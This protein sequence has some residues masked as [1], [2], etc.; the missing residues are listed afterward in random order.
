MKSSLLALSLSL[1][2][3]A[4]SYVEEATAPRTVVFAA[5][6]HSAVPTCRVILDDGSRASI[7][8]LVI[9]GDQ[10]CLGAKRWSIC[11]E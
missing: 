8:A 6:L 9:E 5:C 3:C 1:W 11:G 4:D 10:L 2:G 7:E